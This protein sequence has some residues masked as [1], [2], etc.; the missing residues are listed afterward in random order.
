M[1]VL[2]ASP[3]PIRSRDAP[4]FGLGLA[5]RHD[6]I[7]RLRD[8]LAGPLTVGTLGRITAKYTNPVRAGLGLAPLRRLEQS[9]LAASV[10]LAYTAEPF[11]YPRSDWPAKVH[12]VGPGWWEPPAWLGELRQ[13]LA[14]VT[15]STAFQNDIR[16]AEAACAALAGV[17]FD[18][19]LTTGD[20]DASAIEAPANVHIERFVPHSPVLDRAVCTICH[21]GMGIT[22]KS[23]AH[24]VPVVAVPFGRDQPEVARRVQVA[25]AGIQLP[26]RRLS[27]ARLRAAVHRAIGLRAGAQRVAAAFAAAG[28]PTAAADV[29][30]A[31]QH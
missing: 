11:E 12:L 2:V 1:G 20:V 26:A 15:C 22:Q 31:C 28:G 16:L 7:G 5:P 25:G 19:V 29:L 24:G 23:L 18:V 27:P 6:A 10:V 13:P 9:Y 21:A 3:V 8:R 14:L 30:L 17:P 4:P